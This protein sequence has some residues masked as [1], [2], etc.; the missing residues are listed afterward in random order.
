MKIMSMGDNPQ[1]STGYGQIWEHLLRRWTK[2]K[3]DWKFMHVGWQ[4][5]DREHET[6][7]GY[8]MLPINRQEYGYDV[9]TAH[10]LR[11][12]PDIFLTMADIGLNAGYIDGV[13]EARKQ[14]WNGRWF[15]ICLVDTETWEHV[16]WSKI[17]ESPDKII[18][19]AKNGEI[20][21]NKYGVNN[22]VT[23]P[24][25][26]D[27][28]VF[29]PLEKEERDKLRKNY[30]FD[31]KFVV[32][33]IGKNQRRK[34][35]P[36]L[37]KGF[38]RFSKGKNDVRLLLHTDYSGQN[39]WDVGCLIAKYENEIDKDL[40][41]P[42]KVIFT[43][44]KLDVI[45]RQY[46]NSDTINKIYNL[47]DVY[48]QAVGGEGFG[49]PVLEAQSSGVPAMM[50]NYSAAIEVVSENDLFIPVLKDVH[51]RYV[52]EV[53]ANGVE[54]A[55]PDDVALAEILE[56]LYQEW[57]DGKID[58]RK[59]RAREFA[60]KYNWDDIAKKWVDLFEKEG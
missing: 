49:L 52:C 22:F 42:P 3:P 60:L 11:Q 24:M 43:N 21:Y 6:K 2:L 5:R 47:M 59:K 55:I 33:F 10:L 28:E 51:G 1:T 30:R 46:I 56:K 15:A 41:N 44:E 8:Y 16:F 29:K 39:G 14:G 45:K 36:N 20:L 37:I 40:N 34:T 32:G 26:V 4:N 23:I 13:A 19:G 9:V 31:D 58:E 48:C 38:S 18:C 12:N 17:L 27:S 57:K 25:G 54:N 7:D 53:G 35:I 50:T